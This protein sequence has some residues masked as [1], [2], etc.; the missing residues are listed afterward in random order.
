IVSAAAVAGW[1]SNVLPHEKHESVPVLE[2]APAVVTTRPEVARIGISGEFN[3]AR[4]P[5]EIYPVSAGIKGGLAGS[6]AMAILAIAYGLLSGNGIWYPINLLAAGFFPEALTA[7]TAQ[8]AAFHLRAF[9]IAAVIHLFTSLVVG[10]LY[11][12]MLPMVPRRPIVLGGIIAPVLWSG[13]LHSTLGIINPVL[14]HRI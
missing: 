7:T 11:G 1:F 12:A 9:L 4:V 14:N 8:I 2:E 3:R 6:V 13:L 5:I 10:L